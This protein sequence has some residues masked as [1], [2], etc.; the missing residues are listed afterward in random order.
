LRSGRRRRG[1]RQSQDARAVPPD[2]TPPP[3]SSYSVSNKGVPLTFDEGA[4]AGLARVLHCPSPLRRRYAAGPA[5]GFLQRTNTTRARSSRS[6]GSSRARDV[7]TPDAREMD[8]R[9]FPYPRTVAPLVT[10]QPHAGP[11]E[12]VCADRHELDKRSDAGGSDS[13]GVTAPSYLRP[14]GGADQVRSSRIVSEPA[15]SEIIPLLGHRNLRHTPARLDPRLLDPHVAREGG[16]HSLRRLSYAQDES[17]R[18]QRDL[19]PRRGGPFLGC[20]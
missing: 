5:N 11:R 15:V 18:P 13:C 3:K 8:R 20:L 16:L 7:A 14:R 2:C 10:G 4:V 12:E 1:C 19:S 6:A 17:G 9:P